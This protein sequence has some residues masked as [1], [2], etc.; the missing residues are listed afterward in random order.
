[1]FARLPLVLSTLAALPLFAADAAAGGLSIGYS[2]HGQHSSIGVQIGFPVCERRPAPPQYGGHWETIVER[3]WVPGA[4]ERVWVAP[5]YETRWDPC[6]RPIQ[7]CV[8]A[9]YWDTVQHPGHY[10]DRSTRVWREAG[11]KHG[12]PAKWRHYGG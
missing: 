3:V 1:M 12:G 2:K 5:H 7:V 11:W 8:R 10:E 6:G 4:C 9:G